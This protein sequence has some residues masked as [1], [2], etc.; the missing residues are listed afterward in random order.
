MVA[1]ALALS[2][3]AL[4]QSVQPAERQPGRIVGTV[5]DAN[6]DIVPLATAVLDGHGANDQI[7]KCHVRPVAFVVHAEDIR[8]AAKE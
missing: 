3:T 8:A 7:R 4:A 2:C 1:F 6:N 5:T